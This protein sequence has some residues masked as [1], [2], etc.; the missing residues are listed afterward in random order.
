MHVRL[1]D[2]INSSKGLR[3]S[4]ENVEKSLSVVFLADENMTSARRLPETDDSNT[5]ADGS[6]ER[7]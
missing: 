1:C 7:K 4:V 3:A 5:E 2:A 6:K